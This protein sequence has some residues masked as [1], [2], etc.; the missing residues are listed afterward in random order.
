MNT[1]EGEAVEFDLKVDDKTGKESA[2]NVT[3]PNGQAVIGAD[4]LFQSRGSGYQDRGFDRRGGGRDD[5]ER[6]PRR[7][8]DFDD[9]N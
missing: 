2:L 7:R 5:R 4:A 1:L 8:N 6:R 9:E 3:G